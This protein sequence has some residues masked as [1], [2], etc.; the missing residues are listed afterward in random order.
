VSSPDPDAVL[1]PLL[2]ELAPDDAARTLAQLI[3]RAAAR[4]HTLSRGEASARK[5]QPD[6]PQWAQLQNAARA[7]VLQASTCR[8]LAARLPGPSR[9]PEAGA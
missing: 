5:D 4:L 7:L 9:D 8:D 2:E 6:W 1:K 3:N